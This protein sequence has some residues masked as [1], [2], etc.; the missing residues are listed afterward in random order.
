MKIA[1]VYAHV[2]EH[3]LRGVVYPAWSPGRTWTKLS[4][5]IFRVHTDEGITGIGA[6]T[7]SAALT[8]DLIAPRLIGRDP[9][10]IEQ[11]VRVIRNSGPLWSCMA[12]ACGIEVALWDLLGKAAGLPLY[13]LWGAQT[14]RIRAYASLVEMRGPEQRAE[15][16][17]RLLEQGY[18]GVKLRLHAET[19]REDIAQ[20]EAVRAAVGDRMAIMVDANQAQEP[21]TPG[22]EESVVW[23]YDRALATCRELAHLDVTWVEEPLGR[24][25]YDL[26]TRLTAATDI[27]IA[28]G[29]NNIG[30]HEFRTLIDQN[31]YDIIQ[32]DALVGG[33]L[34]DLRK[35]AAYAGMRQKPTIAHHGG[36]GLGVAAHLHFSASIPNSPWIELL[37]E[38]PTLTVPDFQ[39]L[40]AEPLV[41]RADGFVR[42]PENPGLGVELSDPVKEMLAAADQSGR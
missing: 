30:L 24:Y 9:F 21:G 35:I 2:W 15:D 5:T 31:C 32:P 4:T 22:S 7:G 42:L 19:M 8:R 36:S 23:G 20:V 10:Y 25:E 14:D 29:E 12:I 17:I 13:R 37:Q 34:S 40:L 11:L 41:P 16:V 39:S 1:A 38:P 27:P 26:L 28:G 33:G 3:P 18:T 6:S